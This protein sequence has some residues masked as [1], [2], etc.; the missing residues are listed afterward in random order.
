M[1]DEVSATASESDEQNG[2]LVDVLAAVA[3]VLI[4]VIS[5]IFWLS[6]M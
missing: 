6:G 3:I 5:I 1:N 2:E 4:P